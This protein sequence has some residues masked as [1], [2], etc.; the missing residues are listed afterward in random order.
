MSSELRLKKLRG[1]GGYVMAQVTD[2][3]QR[4]GNL[5]GPDLFLAP[6]G[7]LEQEKISKYYCN[8]CEKDFEGGPKI[9]YESPNEE[10]AQNLILL[11]RGQYMCTTCGSTIAEYREFQKQDQQADVGLAKP[12]TFEQVTSVDSIPQ[13]FA[14]AVEPVSTP[15]QSTQSGSVNSI[16]GMTVYDTNAKRVGTAKQVGVDASHQVVLIVTKGDGQ[17]V[18]IPWSNIKKIGEIVLLGDGSQPS[19]ASQA[20][21]GS[22]GFENKQGSKFCESCGTK[23]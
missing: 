20:K 16:V 3:Q 12:T 4:K 22:C 6:I 5:G 19:Q 14:Q 18:T 2:E 8:T 9:E 15:T 11:E 13:D 17:D 10:V 1:S 7:R 21:C 23:I